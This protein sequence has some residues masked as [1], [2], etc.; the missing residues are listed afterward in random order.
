MMNNLN[1][2]N[3]GVS[4]VQKLWIAVLA[5]VILLILIVWVF[6]F[7]PFSQFL[8]PFWNNN[9]VD[10]LILIPAVGAAMAGTLVMRQFEKNETP[11]RVWRAFTIGLWFWVAGEVSGI[12]YDAIYWDSTYPD[13]RLVD[14]FWLFG[15]F[16]LGLSLY[17]Q[18]RLVYGA[19]NRKGRRL[20]L[21]LVALALLV[22]AGLTN[23]AAR[24][25][26]GAGSAWIILF[27]S[28]LYPVFDLTEGAIAI[29][30]SLLFRRGQWSRPWWGLILFAWADSINTFYWLGGYDRIPVS[31]QD[32][33]DFISLV[34]YPTSYMVAGLALLSNYFILRYG[35]DSGLM[36]SIQKS[37]INKSEI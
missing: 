25:G 13:F 23:M 21:G 14:I 34:A 8:S 24:S 2:S 18:L 37:E 11:Y 5:S 22:T 26:L 15:Y 31:V 12:V 20:Y 32:A 29:W 33:L 16:F 10:I 19:Q 17:Y 3:S 35:E 36:K 6:Y 4:P 1:R 28:V 9:L 27:I 7:E 30:L